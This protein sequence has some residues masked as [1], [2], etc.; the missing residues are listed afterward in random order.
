MR[1]L[2]VF[3][4]WLPRPDRP[5][6]GGALRAWHHGEALRAAGHEVLYITRDQDAVEGGP[7]VFANPSQLRRYARAVHPDRILCVQP[8][9]APRLAD[10]GVPLCVDLYAPRLLEA[11]W[12]SSTD[13]EA[14]STLRALAVADE[15]LFSN[16]RQRWFY[17][18][19]LAIAGV[20]LRRWSGRIV[21]LVAPQGPP[22]RVPRNPVLVMGGVA[23]P[24]QDPTEALRRTVDHLEK[25][26]KGK[27]I[28]F[29]GRPAIGD[30]EVVD[31]PSLVPAGPRLEY[32]GSVP[33]TELLGAYS[34]STAALDLM[35]LNAEREVALAFRHVDYLGC[36]LPII[37]GGYHALDLGEAGWVTDEEGLEDVLD[38]VLDDRDEV[39]R[40]SGA[41]STLA[42]TRYARGVAERALLEWVDEAEKREHMHTPLLDAANLKAELSRTEGEWR[43]TAELLAHAME[44]VEAKRSE[45]KGLNGQIQ[46]LTGTVERLTRTLDEVAGFKREAVRV[47]GSERDAA[48]TEA[49]EL[50]RELSD[51][52]ADLAKKDV[53]LRRGQR[54][55]DRLN[56][57]LAQVK[58]QAS[59]TGE[60]LLEA[61]SRE[62]RLRQERDALKST[63][64][65][66]LLGRV[67]RKIR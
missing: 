8:E 47:L 43:T 9:E 23:W 54:E 32:A 41:A 29:G 31:L 17:L 24:W 6:S 45:V 48:S 56:D 35:E 53:E 61:G 66:G 39:V 2:I 20:D 11:A 14:V 4:G 15:F 16:P 36:G 33:W 19:L 44:E 64:E 7:P 21:P 59:Y 18:G 51:L 57:A 42:Q 52:R 58:D 62:D 25:R 50:A 34:Q 55:Q 60:R 37:T 3:H 30:A 46:S 28:V 26:R 12:Q 49:K 22:R 1:V 10:L 40:R 63:N 27:L 65:G 5:A 13:D 67:L 38:V